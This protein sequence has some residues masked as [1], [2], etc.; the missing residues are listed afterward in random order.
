[1][2]EIT[3]MIHLYDLIALIALKSIYDVLSLS[4]FKREI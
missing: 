2:R 3:Y 4:L 1:M